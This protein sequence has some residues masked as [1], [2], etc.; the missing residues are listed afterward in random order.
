MLNYLLD[1]TANLQFD[2][3]NAN[4]LY[5]KNDVKEYGFFAI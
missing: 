3:V 2:L 5:G 1:Y 4:G